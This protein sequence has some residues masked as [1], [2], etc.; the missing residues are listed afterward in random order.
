M[1][2][3]VVGQQGDVVRKLEEADQD[4]LQLLQLPLVSPAIDGCVIVAADPCSGFVIS[5]LS[6]ASPA[7]SLLLTV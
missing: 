2:A 4:V 1:S 7:E 6:P 5:A 3:V